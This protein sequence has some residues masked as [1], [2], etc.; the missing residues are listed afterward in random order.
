MTFEQFTTLLG[1]FPERC[2][3]RPEITA[4]RDRGKYL[5]HRI[6][7][8]VEPGERIAAFLLVPNDAAAPFPAVFAHHQH[9]GEFDIG[10]SEVVGLA[11]DPHQAYARELAERGFVVI[12][13]DCVGFE[14]RNESLG[15]D[16]ALQKM[17]GELLA[18]GKT[19][20][21]KVI[22]D[23]RVAI[24]VL[25]SREEVD[26]TRIGFI[27]HSYGGRTALWITAFE[28]R[29]GVVVS[30]CGC[31]PYS[32][33]RKPDAGVQLEFR[34]PGLEERGELGD[35]LAFG[36][37]TPTLILAADDDKW[38]RG[39]IA[40]YEAA[41][42][43]FPEGA[44]NYRSWPGPHSFTPEMRTAAYQFLESHLGRR[45]GASP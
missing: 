1:P 43:A 42:P 7:Y 10:K 22:H 19:L 3:P 15:S 30:S 8:D 20:M 13:P 33:M 21:A 39:G 6:E 17:H 16:R 5:E 34:V 29:V 4:T 25:A 31:A 27:G 32:A 28:S 41:R 45:S 35:V 14:E 37:P 24:D 9:A 40:T 2:P 23:I 44:L 26:S 12:A 38:S 36:S 18:Q 11:G